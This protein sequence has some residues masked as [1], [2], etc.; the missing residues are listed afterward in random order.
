MWEVPDLPTK[1]WLER[2]KIIKEEKGRMWCFFLTYTGLAVR[3]GRF[4]V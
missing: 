3:P 1:I 4:S 2:F